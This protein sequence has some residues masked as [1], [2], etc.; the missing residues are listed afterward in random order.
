VV[1]AAN[2]TERSVVALG[3]RSRFATLRAP[4]PRCMP[5]RTT[6]ELGPSSGSTKHALDPWLDG[7]AVRSEGEVHM[8]ISIIQ[9][10]RG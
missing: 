5:A 6:L 3:G 2:G 8:A 7:R 9:C 10:W 1:G 4:S